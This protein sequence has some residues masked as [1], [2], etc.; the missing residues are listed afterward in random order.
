MIKFRTWW[1]APN[2]L[3]DRITAAIV[4]SI[5]GFWIGLLGRILIGELPVSFSETGYWALGT[6]LMFSMLGVIF[7]KVIL[8]LCFPFSIFG[9]GN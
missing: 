1:S 9:I 4:G 6:A 8:C 2:T 7:P 3:K 5:G